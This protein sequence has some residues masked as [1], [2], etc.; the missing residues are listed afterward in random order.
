MV[1][2]ACSLARDP[3]CLT[4]EDRGHFCGHD[5]LPQLAIAINTLGNIEI[6]HLTP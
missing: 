4:C 2:G 6:A 5:G 3:A 1:E